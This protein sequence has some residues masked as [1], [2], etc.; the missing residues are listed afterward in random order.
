MI[1]VAMAELL[2]PREYYTKISLP[3][4]PRGFAIELPVNRTI[5]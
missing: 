3:H 2:Y 4:D 5:L 1:W